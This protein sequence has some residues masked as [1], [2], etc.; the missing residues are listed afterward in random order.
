MPWNGLAVAYAVP[1]A[2]ASQRNRSWLTIAIALYVKGQ[3][4]FRSRPV[5]LYRIEGLAYT[6]GEPRAYEFS[7]G[8]VR[9]SCSECG[10]SLEV[11]FKDNPK[12]VHVY[13]GCLYD[14]NAVRQ[15]FHA[16]TSTQVNWC[17]MAAGLPRHL[18]LSP[19]AE[20]IWTRLEGWKPVE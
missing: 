10:S 19:E 1:C 3:L 6:K 5:P 20:K 2:S 15:E 8:V 14:P 18:E 11:P 12:L 4:E 13:L 17:E 9:L 16:F 7:P